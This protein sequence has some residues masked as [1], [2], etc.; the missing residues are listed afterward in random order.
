MRTDPICVTP[1]G[2]VGRS[3]PAHE[4]HEDSNNLWLSYHHLLLFLVPLQVGKAL[5]SGQ[6][7]C[8]SICCKAPLAM[9][10]RQMAG[11]LLE[12]RKLIDMQYTPC[13]R[14][15]TSSWS[16]TSGLVPLANPNS[17]P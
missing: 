1:L 10:P 7:V 4:S 12:A 11:V 2:T 14:I 3:V 13:A 15:G 6:S 17:V 8:I 9:G 16:T 5:R